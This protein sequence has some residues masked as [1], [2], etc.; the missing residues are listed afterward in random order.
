M[1]FLTDELRRR[2]AKDQRGRC[3]FCHLRLHE[4]MTW[5]HLVPRSHKGDNRLSNMRIAHQ[6]CNGEC[7]GALPVSWKYI[8]HDVGRDYGSDAFFLLAK[9]AQDM[10]RAGTL[11]YN[12]RARRPKRA[13]FRIHR[14]N[15]DLLLSYL[16]QDM[17]FPA[18][19]A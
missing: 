10:L 19:A 11:P 15:L 5:E 13:P 12:V 16:P 18:I 8:L 6:R 9:R 14:E 17:E 4:D 7:V 2:Q 1:V 3:W